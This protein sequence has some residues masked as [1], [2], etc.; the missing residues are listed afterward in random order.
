MTFPAPSNKNNTH[1]SNTYT[2]NTFN[3]SN[4]PAMYVLLFLQHAGHEYAITPNYVH[5]NGICIRI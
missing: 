3:S 4:T 2:W 5:I 1:L